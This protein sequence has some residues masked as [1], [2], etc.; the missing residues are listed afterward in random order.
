[1]LITAL[2]VVVIVLVALFVF[3][4][5]VPLPGKAHTV[6][7]VVVGLLLFLY[8][9]DLFFGRHYLAQLTR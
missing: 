8:L 9:V 5:L 2:V 7:R 6:I 3:Q 1:M 4:L